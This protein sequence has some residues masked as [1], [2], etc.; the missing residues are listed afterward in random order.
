QPQPQ[1]QVPDVSGGPNMLVTPQDLNAAAWAGST[2]LRANNQIRTPD[3]KAAGKITATKKHFGNLL[4]QRK[5]F[6]PNTTYT[7]SATVKKINH[8][9]VGLRISNSRLNAPGEALPFVDL[10]T[11]KT[12]VPAGIGN[13]SLTAK[14]LGNGF[15]R[16]TLHYKTEANPGTVADIALVSSGGLHGITTNG[17]EQV[18]VAD[19]VLTESGA[20]TL[21]PVAEPTPAPVP[22][23]TPVPAPAPS[24]NYRIHPSILNSGKIYH[25]SLSGNDGNDGSQAKPFRT[26]A[27]ALSKV[28]A[29]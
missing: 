27:A 26:L 7:L 24:G 3:G 29:G 13:A 20:V 19:P 2:V 10:D 4:R 22:T 8:A 12:T 21:P 16:L 25:A 9:Y 14:A 6:K 17:T 18:Y 28:P 23:P 5:T 15:Y 1:P 11:G